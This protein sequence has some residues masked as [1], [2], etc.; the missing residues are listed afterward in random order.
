MTK[1][2][3]FEIACNDGPPITYV[4]ADLDS[5]PTMI[6]RLKLNKTTTLQITPMKIN[7]G[8]LDSA[9]EGWLEDYL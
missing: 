4:D 8:L 7:Q 3:V 6:R 9:E 5:L 1:V 2:K